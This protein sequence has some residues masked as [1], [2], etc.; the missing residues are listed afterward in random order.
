QDGASNPPVPVTFTI[1]KYIPVILGNAGNGTAELRY[2]SGSHSQAICTFRGPATVAHPVTD[3]ERARGTRY[4]FVSCNNG[5][6]AGDTTLGTDFQLKVVSGDA[7][8]PGHATW[9]ELHLGAG[10]SGSL[11]PSIMPDE[12]VSL[13]ESFSWRRMPRLPDRDPTGKP[14]L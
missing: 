6:H 11:P 13:R 8:W 12:L 2:R 3:L 9:I 1:P 14:A 7:Q 4:D 5:L 10:C